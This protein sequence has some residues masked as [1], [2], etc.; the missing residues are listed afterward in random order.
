MENISRSA[1]MPQKKFIISLFL[2]TPV[3]LDIT[4]IF[5]KSVTTQL[6]TLDRQS[7]RIVLTHILERFSR[8]SRITFYISWRN[9]QGVGVDM[10][11]CQEPHPHPP[12]KKDHLRHEKDTFYFRIYHMYYV[13]QTDRHKWL[14]I[15]GLYP[16]TLRNMFSNIKLSTAA[17]FSSLTKIT[18]SC[19]YILWETLNLWIFQ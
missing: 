4:Q 15:S 17:V 9:Q 1:W 3:P 12:I 18:C 14:F 13:L 11:I 7:G 10:L 8:G 6:P 19:I 5:P 16:F 2:P